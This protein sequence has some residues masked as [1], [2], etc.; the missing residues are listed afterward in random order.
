MSRVYI[1]IRSLDFGP[2]LKPRGL[3]SLFPVPAVLLLQLWSLAL[4]AAA[5]C[6]IPDMDPV[7]LSL[8]VLSALDLCVT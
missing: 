8:A 3:N 5:F 1:V 6:H 2:K 7:S 4:L